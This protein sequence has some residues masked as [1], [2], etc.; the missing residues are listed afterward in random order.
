M[1]GGREQPEHAE[2]TTSAATPASSDEVEPADAGDE[3]HG[4]ERGRV[5][6]RR[7][8]V[9]LEEDEQRS[10]RAPSPIAVERPSAARRSAAPRSARK[11]ASAR[12]KSS[13]PNSDG[14]NWNGPRS[15]Q[16]FE[17]RDRLGEREDEHHQRRSCRRR[18]TRQWR[19]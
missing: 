10:A 15:I 11:P 18:S 16:R 1:P 3:E 14:W 4:G 9:R 12:T 8:E 17:P 6:E 19:R 7:A 13:L 5:D 2:T